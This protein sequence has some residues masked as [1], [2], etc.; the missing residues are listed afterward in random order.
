MKLA[1]VAAIAATPA[2][3]TAE[4]F[5]DVARAAAPMALDELVWT[6]TSPCTTG[7]DVQKR[8]CRILHERAKAARP[9][10][11]LVEAERA[12]LVTGA[13]DEA[14]RSLPV[15]LSACLRC[16]QPIE[17][18]GKPW[19]VVAGSRALFTDRWTFPDAAAARARLDAPLRIELVVTK[20]KLAQGKVEVTSAGFRIVTP[21]DGKVVAA[22]PAAAN[23]PPDKKACPRKP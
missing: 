16:K 14:Q 15:E 20:P 18:A 7:D 12:A 11:I 1:L 10:A 2:I 9:A 5:E 23:L 19:T 8:Q 13:F 3:A 4:T 22:V 17:I 21:C 6:V